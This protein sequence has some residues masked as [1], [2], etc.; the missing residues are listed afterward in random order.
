MD[1]WNHSSYDWKLFSDNISVVRAKYIE[2]LNLLPDMYSRISSVFGIP[3]HLLPTEAID[4]V[5]KMLITSL[6]PEKIVPYMQTIT[7][8]G[9]F[10]A[11]YFQQQQGQGQSNND[12]RFKDAEWSNNPFFS[13]IKEY[14]SQASNILNNLTETA[15]IVDP[16]VKHQLTFYTKQF[17]YAVAPVNFPF[18]N[19]E[20]IRVTLE[21]HGQNLIDGASNLI[22]DINNAIKTGKFAIP[23]TD[24]DAFSLGKNIAITPGKVVFQNE[25]LQLIQ[26]EATTKEVNNNPLLIVPAW[27]N[28]YYVLDLQEHNSMVK[29][30]VEQGYTVFMV[31]WVNPGSEFAEKSMDDYMLSGVIKAIEKAKE[32]SKS[33]KLDCIGYCLGGTMLAISLAYLAHHKKL[34]EYINSATFLASLVDFQDAGDVSVFVDESQLSVLENM[35]KTQGYLDGYYMALCF[36]ILRAP[37]MIWHY[38]INNYMLGKKP[39]A[40]DILYWNSDSTRMP[41]KMHSQYLRQLYLHNLL[42]NAGGITVGGVPIDLSKIDIPTY[43]LATT[44]DHIAPWR[45][46]Y[47]AINIYK[48][49]NIFVL[50][51]SGHVVGIVNPPAKNKYSYRVCDNHYLNPDEWFQNSK[52]IPGSWWPNW[53]SW[54]SKLNNEK[55]PAR[56]INNKVIIE[57]AP[58]GYVKKK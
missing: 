22:S 21:S 8:V 47:S 43:S 49:K 41:Y 28:K 3:S 33:S 4:S 19:P 1:N 20:V 14:Y 50:S 11:P 15:P 58:G 36:S 37:E 44:E 16:K 13:Y 12:R 17:L 31:S 6:S 54:N 55:V 39:Q 53:L 40:F 24:L 48:G 34:K 32:L 57:E 29:W 27:I 30:L 52:E 35:M 23:T 10:F 56:Q 7:S 45:S 2:C 38:Y 9:N 25:M 5:I 51:G 26:Y 42:K 46:V 18:L